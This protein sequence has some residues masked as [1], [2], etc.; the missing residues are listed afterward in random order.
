VLIFALAA[1]VLYGT[2][3][4]LGG[5]A[6]RRASPFTVI[7]VAE[8]AGTV[9]LL[10][11][12][13]TVSLAL[14]HAGRDALAAFG[15]WGSVA[16]SAG[17]G[18]AGVTGL[19]A[20]FT[21]FAKAP[22]SVVA[23]VSALVSTVLP[24]GVALAG[25]ERPDGTVIAGALL[26]LAAIMLV[27][28]EP[29]GAKGGRLRGLGYGVAAGVGFGL[30][31]VLM[32]NAGHSAVLWPLTVQRLASTV[33]AFGVLAL[34]WTGTGTIR[35]LPRDVLRIAFFSG[36]FD[37]CANVCYVL[38]TRAGQFGLAVVITALYPGATVLLAR[39]VLRERMRVVQQAGL[40]LAVAGIVLVTV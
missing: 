8:P 30:Y 2:G 29:G 13:L 17:A 12:A 20:F 14:P 5:F 39:V 37:A 6:T 33:V 21:G 11:V 18:V 3:D 38:A 26:C 22:M 16:W 7:A 23:P 15:G 4:F 1:A 35:G 27:S 25:G 28:A 36:A 24:I 9:V 31:F 32:R 10:A 34:P 40:V 19:F